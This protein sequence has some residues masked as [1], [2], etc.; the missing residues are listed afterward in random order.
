MCC[1]RLQ[2]FVRVGGT[3]EKLVNNRNIQPLE[4]GTVVLGDE[5]ADKDIAFSDEEKQLPEGELRGNLRQLWL[6]KRKNRHLSALL[7]IGGWS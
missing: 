4:D 1:M 5:W 3:T 6:L 2:R 7:S